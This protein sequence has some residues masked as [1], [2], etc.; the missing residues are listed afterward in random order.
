MLAL[1]AP[2]SHA[3][4]GGATF[5]HDAQLLEISDIVKIALRD[6]V[7]RHGTTIR[8]PRVSLSRSLSLSLSLSLCLSLCLSLSLSLSLVC[9]CFSLSIS[10]LWLKAERS[11]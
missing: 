9:F 8:W 5:G 6:M 4:Q 2:S 7:S 3:K 10:K 11:P 1:G